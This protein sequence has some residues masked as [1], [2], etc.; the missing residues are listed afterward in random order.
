[1]YRPAADR[2][3]NA[4]DRGLRYS[5]APGM[6]AHRYVTLRPGQARR[7][8]RSSLACL[9][10]VL[11]PL[12]G[13]WLA[14]RTHSNAIAGLLPWND[15]AGYYG[16]ALQ[17]LDGEGVS[18]FC[19]GRPIYLLYLAG[20][21]RF[22][23]GGLAWLGQIGGGAESP[24]PP[25]TPAD[26]AVPVT[27]TAIILVVMSALAWPAARLHPGMGVAEAAATCGGDAPL[28]I[29]PG[30]GSPV[31]RIASRHRI[32]P[33]A[34]PADDFRAGL[35][36]QTHGYAELSALP[37]GTAIIYAF[38]LLQAGQGRKFVLLGDADQLPMDG[39]RI[40]VCVAPVPGS[41]AREARR[42]TA[43]HAIE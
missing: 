17:I 9:A 29:R 13:F 41:V 42:I 34:I 10:G 28:V 12:F 25:P 16:R 21:I 23:G 22:G 6:A 31:A 20:L 5:G 43:V 1:M 14:G 32:W 38:D 26:W 37:E 27:L 33:I 39:R 35:H 36:P 2:R 11:L 18:P 7:R 8:H 30:R 3:D 40:L 19:E 4:G 24:R 15:A